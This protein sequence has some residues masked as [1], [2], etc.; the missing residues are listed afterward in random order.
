[1]G[2]ISVSVA[3]AAYLHCPIRGQL[4]EPILYLR[5]RAERSPVGEREVQQRLESH[6]V[7]FDEL[8]VG[9]YQSINDQQERQERV[10]LDYERFL[11]RRAEIVRE[12]MV[13]LCTG[14]QWPQ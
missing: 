10:K 9:G 1:M 2:A 6:L 12:A 3:E 11:S 5:E 8:A 4:K 14:E 13:R 7:P